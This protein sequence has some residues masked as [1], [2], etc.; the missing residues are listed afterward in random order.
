MTVDLQI[1][2]LIVL[3]LIIVIAISVLLLR[4]PDRSI[5]IVT[6]YLIFFTASYLLA[7]MVQL[8]PGYLPL[9]DPRLT[10]L[11]FTAGFIGLLGFIFG[12]L[13]IVPAIW[14]FHLSRKIVKSTDISTQPQPKYTP[15]IYYM[16]G[17][18]S[19]FVFIPALGH[20]PTV[21][22]ILTNTAKLLFVGAVLL[23]YQI[24]AGQ[25]NLPRWLILIPVFIWPLVTLI[26]EGFLS[27]GFVG[28]AIT[29]IFLFQMSRRDFRA[30]R[31]VL[32]L[33][34][35]YFL[36]SLMSTYFVARNQIRR[37]VWGGE[38]LVDRFNTV[39]ET[40]F[41]EFVLFDPAY[42]E[43]LRFIEDRAD[44]SN[45]TGIAIDYIE[46]G[47][48]NYTYGSTL[49]DSVLMLIPRVL[50]PDKPFEVGGHDLITQ[51]TGIRFPYGT[52]VG[53]GQVM[54]LYI[55]FGLIG[56]IVGFI[57]IG[58]IAGSLDL[59]AALAIP[60]G[61]YFGASL[62]MLPAFGFLLIGDDM[63]TLTG[64]TGAAIGAAVFVNMA[65]RIVGVINRRNHST[66]VSK[67]LSYNRFE[68]RK[69]P[70]W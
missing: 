3:W 4:R 55:N 21:S 29:L 61:N 58:I 26:N 7:P 44:L 17:I 69:G 9:R 52:S 27:F 38:A 43:R 18:L 36:L 62:Y 40:L 57:V 45:Q 37:S 42:P 46:S 50:W 53:T 47:A 59:G 23:I 11:G 25:I 8:L 2:P 56:I 39:Y 31:I 64:T 35:G 22:A 32:G 19:Y 68:A 13:V 1:W 6:A 20:I 41:Q 70:R 66:P 48:V 54:E 67:T 60:K 49:V 15:L 12:A 5:G 24:N 33:V 14:Q 28:A 63:I 51:Y 30:R 65:I 34:V 10:Q 16:L